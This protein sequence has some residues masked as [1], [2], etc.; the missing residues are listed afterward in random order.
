MSKTPQYKSYDGSIEYSP[1]DRVL[2]G[3]LV[4]IRDAVVYEGTDVDSIESNFRVAVDE[5]LGFCAEEGKAPDRSVK[6][7]LTD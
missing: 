5:Y 6:W 2:H 4:G 1:E 3:S 7:P